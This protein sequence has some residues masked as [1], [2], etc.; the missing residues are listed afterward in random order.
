[1]AALTIIVGF[2]VGALGIWLTS[3]F[4]RF[5]RGMRTQCVQL[6]SKSEVVETPS[7]LS[8]MAVTVTGLRC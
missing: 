3:A 2:I 4:V 6:R 1:M 5:Q 7:A 8:N